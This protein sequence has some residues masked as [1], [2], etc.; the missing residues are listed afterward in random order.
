MDSLSKMI[1]NN[2]D[3]LKDLDENMCR[4]ITNKL[5]PY[6]KV[7]GSGNKPVLFSFTNFREDRMNIQKTLSLFMF[8]NKLIDE[9]DIWSEDLKEQVKPEERD[10]FKAHLSLFRDHFL[11]YSEKKDSTP[12]SHTGVDPLASLDFISKWQRFETMNFKEIQETLN[13]NLLYKTN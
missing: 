6:S 4:S 13:R 10:Q 11:S 12:S 9:H 1:I 5:N 7:V 3:M 8:M 2:P